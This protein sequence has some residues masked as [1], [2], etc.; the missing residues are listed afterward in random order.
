M[1]APC[2][3]PLALPE[4]NTWFVRIYAFRHVH[5]CALCTYLGTYMTTDHTDDGMW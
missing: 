2:V 3:F 1:F 4:G 5:V